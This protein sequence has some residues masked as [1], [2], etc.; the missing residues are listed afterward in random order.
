MIVLF[1]LVLLAVLAIPDARPS[2]AAI[3]FSIGPMIYDVDYFVK[4]WLKLQKTS[5]FLRNLTL[6]A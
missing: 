6:R 3:F 1:I 4:E 2:A 5:E